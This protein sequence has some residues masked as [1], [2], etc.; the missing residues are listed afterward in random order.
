MQ[1]KLYVGTRV[2]RPTP[3]TRGEYNAFRGWTVPENENPNDAGYMLTA[4]NIGISNI[5]DQDKY[6]NWL[7]AA[8]FERSYREAEGLTF[9]DAIEAMKSG[10]C[11]SR[12]GWNGAGMYVYIERPV[13]MP[14][15]TR[16]F[17]MMKTV[18]GELVPWTV[19]QSDALSEDWYIVQ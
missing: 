5:L 1:C 10:H 15:K 9:G 18:N 12:H 4:L 17:M 6:V 7:P 14:R 8:I 3:M 11:V 2:V 13:A 19:S 16:P